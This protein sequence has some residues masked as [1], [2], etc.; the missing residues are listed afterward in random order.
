MKPAA[1]RSARGGPIAALACAL[2]LAGACTAPAG[3]LDA[4]HARALELG[5]TRA[6]ELPALLGTPDQRHRV[7]SPELDSEILRYRESA[8]A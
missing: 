5:V 1:G 3:R 4:A 7:R 2:L 8:S 6:D